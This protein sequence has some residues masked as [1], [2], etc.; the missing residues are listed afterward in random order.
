MPRHEV[1]LRCMLPRAVPRRRLLL[2]FGLFA[3]TVYAIWTLNNQAARYE[4]KKFPDLATPLAAP[5]PAPSAVLLQGS[6]QPPAPA[7]SAQP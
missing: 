2:L 4:G 1:P 3:A 5:Q 6:A 7:A